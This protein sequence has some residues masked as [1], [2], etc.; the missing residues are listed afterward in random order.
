MENMNINKLTGLTRQH[1]FIMQKQK[2]S[3]LHVKKPFLC[4]LS[5]LRIGMLREHVSLGISRE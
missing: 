5:R 4:S 2:D 3:P 1:N